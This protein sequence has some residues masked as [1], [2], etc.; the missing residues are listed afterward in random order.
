MLL[1]STSQLLTTCIPAV[2][3]LLRNT[4]LL[5]E[6]SL[7]AMELQL[8]DGSVVPCNHSIINDLWSQPTAKN[9]I[10]TKWHFAVCSTLI[11]LSM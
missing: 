11:V 4:H 5:V 3:L 7:V 10:D 8:L 6:A 2:D 9:K 1:F